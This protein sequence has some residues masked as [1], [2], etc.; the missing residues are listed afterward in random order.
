MAGSNAYQKLS[1]LPEGNNDR[2]GTHFSR[3]FQ[4]TPV[5]RSRRDIGRISGPVT[6]QMIRKSMRCCSLG[7]AGWVAL[8][9]LAWQ[10]A[11]AG[12]ETLSDWIA[13]Q[14]VRSWQHLQQN[15]SPQTPKHP[16]EPRP[17]AGIVVAALQMKDPDYY[18]H[19]AR[20]SALVMHTIAEAFELRRPYT[21]RALFERQFGDFLKLSR[22]LQTLPSTFGLGEPR[23]TVNGA[24]DPLPWSR[25][26]FDGPALRALCV[27][28]YFRAESARQVQNPERDALAREILQTDLDYLTTVWNQRGFDV[29]E[30]LLADNY[31]T[32]LVQLAA[33]EQGAE[34]FERRGDTSERVLRYRNVVR[35]LEPLLE[36]HWD[37]TRGFLRSQLAIVATD[38]FTAKNTDLD[39]E[40][41]VAVVD[42]DRAGVAQSVLDD[43]VQATV[44]VLEDLFRTSFPINRRA[45]VGLGYGRYRGDTYYGG[46]AWVFITADFATFYYRL[47]RRLK[48]G[49]SLKVSSLN[50]AFLRAALPAAS[51]GWLK[52]GI[53]A[54]R[55]SLHRAAIE[56]FALKGDRILERLR[57]STPADG[58]MYEQIDKRTGAPASSR[59]IG[60]SHAAFLTAVYEREQLQATSVP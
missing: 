55:S 32:R 8:F 6:V 23:Y 25:P 4:R 48:E 19:W 27:L 1:L 41:I 12:P 51:S 10:P 20:D 49:A 15:I 31:Q 43:R 53:A 9:V 44:A 52:E 42:A 45:D 46:N 50:I 21:S 30:E 56:A 59:G 7:R 37:P 2:S 11:I 3:V 14:E 5:R 18:F 58:Q 33:L 13:Q 47:A 28:E 60:W 38:G 34:W 54:P 36:D 22:H 57:V 16:A 24:V 17:L 40:V 26:Q 39:S 35:L 29:W